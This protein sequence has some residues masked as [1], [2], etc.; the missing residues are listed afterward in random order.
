[1]IFSKKGCR[2]AFSNT[3]HPTTTF[4]QVAPWVPAHGS[5]RMS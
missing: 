4:T 3:G 2:M 5:L 1:M